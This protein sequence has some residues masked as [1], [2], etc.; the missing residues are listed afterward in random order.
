MSGS[1]FL[2]SGCCCNGLKCGQGQGCTHTPN[3]FC[4]EAFISSVPT[5]ARAVGPAVPSLSDPAFFFPF[6]AVSDWAYDNINDQDVFFTR[7][8]S[9]IE[10]ASL[11]SGATT[12]SCEFISPIGYYLNGR[13]NGS[14]YGLCHTEPQ[15]FRLLTTS[16][17]F[18]FPWQFTTTFTRSVYISIIFNSPTSVTV[19]GY[20]VAGEPPNFP[21]SADVAYGVFNR[22]TY[23]SSLVLK[24]Y[25]GAS[26]VHEWFRAT[27]TVSSSWI[28][29]DGFPTSE[30]VFTNQYTSSDLHTVLG[31][32]GEWREDI[33]QPT[34][35]PIKGY[36][37]AYDGEITIRKR[38]GSNNNRI[39][40]NKIL[41]RDIANPDPD[42][43]SNAGSVFDHGALG[44][45]GCTTQPHDPDTPG[46]P[47]DGSGGGGGKPP[48]SN[49]PFTP[50][51]PSETTVWHRIRRCCSGDVTDQYVALPADTDIT[52][53]VAD[54]GRCYFLDET[55]IVAIR[56]NGSFV[57]YFERTTTAAN[58]C[59]ALSAQ[60]EQCCPDCARWQLVD[61]DGVE[62]D[63]YTCHDLSQY[64]GQVIKFSQDATASCWNVI[65]YNG[66]HEVTVETVTV[67]ES[68]ASC[69]ECQDP[70]SNP[71]HFPIFGTPTYPACCF[72]DTSKL[73]NY[74]EEYSD[75]TVRLT[76]N[77]PSV[78]IGTNNIL[79]EV[80]VN[81]SIVGVPD[82]TV[83]RQFRYSAGENG[84]SRNIKG[85]SPTFVPFRNRPDNSCDLAPTVD[86]Q[87]CKGINVTHSNCNNGSFTA[88]FDITNNGC[89]CEN[90]CASVANCVQGTD[91]DG[92]G[93]RDP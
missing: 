26:I 85:A 77:G 32:F 75:G 70:C 49:P 35:I 2:K 40:W 52:G 30:E 65:S 79:F 80:P 3:G 47:G 71:V 23:Q 34:V 74:V 7:E 15:V 88:S 63:V 6:G 5:I 18:G 87:N 58:P 1:S 50:I 73:E 59:A 69:T 39:E 93:A 76:Q 25:H 81:V 53:G 16:I 54:D 86:N 61:C 68:S 21:N 84:W 72:S 4:A 67:T 36:V 55:R 38:T 44:C 20:M 28:G 46:P 83:I 14:D 43:R 8:K 31:T 13:P 37:I 82:Y 24:F 42:K 22:R 11:V 12:E 66:D 89:R 64:E 45:I 29:S 78:W 27:K 62:L 91:A 48:D 9:W 10:P 57:R 92:D 56:P 60:G 90:P 17:N 51:G 19:V 33:C 41:G